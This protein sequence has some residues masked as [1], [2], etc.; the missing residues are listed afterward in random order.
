[1]PILNETELEEQLQRWST[2]TAG[3]RRALS[4][5]LTTTDQMSAWQG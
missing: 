1:L 2:L 4:Q 5:A 3:Q